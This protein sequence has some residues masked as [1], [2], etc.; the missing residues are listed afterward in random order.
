VSLPIVGSLHMQRHPPTASM[1]PLVALD[2]QPFQP[3]PNLRWQESWFVP[4]LA[5]FSHFSHHLA[6]SH[7]AFTTIRCL[8]SYCS[9]LS[10]HLCHFLTI[11]LLFP[12]LSYGADLFPPSKCHFSKMAVHWRQVQSWVSNCFMT[13]LLPILA[14]EACFPLL[15]VL[16]LHKRR[17]A[18]LRSLCSP[19]QINPASAC[20]CRSFPS[21]LKFGV[22]DSHRPLSP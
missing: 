12:I 17:M 11:S 1:P 14:A 9:G 16:L 22:P 15:S 2:C 19:P 6:L 18:T 7:S 4:N 8:S 5:S 20:L 3:S 21:H 13:T 10:P